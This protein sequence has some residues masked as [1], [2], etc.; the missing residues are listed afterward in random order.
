MA[1]PGAEQIPDRPHRELTLTDSKS[2]LIEGAGCH[3]QE[4]AGRELAD[5]IGKWWLG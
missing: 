4:E 5:E 3:V 1:R 2:V